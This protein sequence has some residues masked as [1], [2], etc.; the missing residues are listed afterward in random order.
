[1]SVQEVV[2]LQW[3]AV[4]SQVGESSVPVQRRR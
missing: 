3:A 1:M 2:M 4:R